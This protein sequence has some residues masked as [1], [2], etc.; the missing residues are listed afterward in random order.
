MCVYMLCAHT[1][2]VK[3]VL[4]A[5]L[6]PAAVGRKTQCPPRAICWTTMS[7]G[8]KLA[9]EALSE[10]HISLS[11]LAQLF[12]VSCHLYLELFLSSSILRS[13]TFVL[14]WTRYSWDSWVRILVQLQLVSR[15]P[16]GKV[17]KKE[18]Y[19]NHIW[20]SVVEKK[21]MVTVLARESTSH[22]VSVTGFGRWKGLGF[23]FKTYEHLYNDSL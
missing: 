7:A 5:S 14:L 13:R 17:H 1:E 8:Y 20:S 22:N 3:H 16:R 11:L 4:T 2:F 10:L 12:L 6:K 18:V 15:A 21:N 19:S 23:S 9:I